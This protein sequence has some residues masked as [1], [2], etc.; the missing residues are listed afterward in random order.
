MCSYYY[1]QEDVCCVV[2]GVVPIWHA[3]NMCALGLKCLKWLGLQKQ[4]ENVVI[5]RTHRTNIGLDQL[6]KEDLNGERGSDGHMKDSW[7][8]CL[9]SE[10]GVA[11]SHCSFFLELYPSNLENRVGFP[12]LEPTPGFLW[13]CVWGVIDHHLK[14]CVRFGLIRSYQW[15]WWDIAIHKT[16]KGTASNLFWLI[17]QIQD[18]QNEL[19][20]VREQV[21]RGPGDLW[22]CVI[23]DV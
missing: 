7:F 19:A 11:P 14:R 1:V 16:V 13:Q 17:W 3:G 20:D 2:Y 23:Q 5:W 21:A 15:D 4:I 9:K 8:T 10:F 22:G 18:A 12:P 6:L